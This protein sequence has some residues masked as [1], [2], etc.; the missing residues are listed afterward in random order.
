MA[1]SSQIRQISSPYSFGTGPFRLRSGI[2][3]SRGIVGLLKD[4]EF[5]WPEFWSL[6]VRFWFVEFW[7]E[8]WIVAKFWV[9]VELW[10]IAGLFESIIE[11]K[12]A[13]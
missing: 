1:L 12:L 7:F 10:P 2:L 5:D 4:F 13:I 3:L 8:T 11:K 6:T 9:I